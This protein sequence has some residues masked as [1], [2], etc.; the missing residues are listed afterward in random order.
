MKVWGHSQCIILDV[1]EKNKHEII[2]LMRVCH[3]FQFGKNAIARVLSESQNKPRACRNAT[4]LLGHS[5]C[6]IWEVQDRKSVV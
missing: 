4:K 3:R 2:F 5:Q 6:V 1:Q